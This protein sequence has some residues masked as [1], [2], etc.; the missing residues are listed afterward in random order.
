MLLEFCHVFSP[1]LESYS[2]GVKI[3]AQS[4]SL[5][6][7]LHFEEDAQ[8]MKVTCPAHIGCQWTRWLEKDPTEGW[9]WGKAHQNIHFVL[10][11]LTEKKQR[12]GARHISMRGKGK[13]TN[14]GGN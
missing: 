2:K 5:G 7:A 1:G 9:H 3:G 14:R 13:E 8:R 11:F 6:Q 12:E 10:T 4:N